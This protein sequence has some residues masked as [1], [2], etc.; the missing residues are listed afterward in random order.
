M[1]SSSGIEKRGMKAKLWGGALWPWPGHVDEDGASRD[2]GWRPGKG[3]LGKSPCSMGCGRS[4]VRGEQ[5]CLEE[6]QEG[7]VVMNLSKFSA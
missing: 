1:Q 6:S 5:R 3:V 4:G 2:A 7:E